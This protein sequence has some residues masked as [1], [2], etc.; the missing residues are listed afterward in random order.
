VRINPKKR[1]V[2]N[3][4]VLFFQPASCGKISLRCPCRSPRMPPANRMPGEAPQVRHDG[5]PNAAPPLSDVVG[6]KSVIPED[7]D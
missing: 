6:L 4:E 7:H 3:I 2:E 1:E 5:V